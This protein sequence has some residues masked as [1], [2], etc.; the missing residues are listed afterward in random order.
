M[1]SYLD[2]KTDLANVIWWDSM[3][4]HFLWIIWKQVLHIL[5]Q[6]KIYWM[7]YSILQLKE[8]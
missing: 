1:D 3:T 2:N 7:I 6:D 8:F 4:N 5:L